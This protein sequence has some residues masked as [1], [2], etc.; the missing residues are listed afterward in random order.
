ME[1]YFFLSKESLSQEFKDGLIIW[2]TQ[3]QSQ[4]NKG[5]KEEYGGQGEGKRRILETYYNAIIIKLCDI[6]VLICT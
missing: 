1:Y 5:L 6:S 3:E 2:K 4:P